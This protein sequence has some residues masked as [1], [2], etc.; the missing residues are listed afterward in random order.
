MPGLI[1]D[2]SFGKMATGMGR[3]RM[4]MMLQKIATDRNTGTASWPGAYNAVIRAP[5]A[6]ADYR[7]CT[8]AVL[9]CVCLQ[10]SHSLPFCPTLEEA[11]PARQ[12]WWWC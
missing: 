1:S 5:F 10:V 8:C 4:M 7:Y 11:K 6:L 12:V 3:K 9:E 2:N